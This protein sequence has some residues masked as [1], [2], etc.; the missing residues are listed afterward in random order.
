V[1]D[2][3]VVRL[4]ERLHSADMPSAHSPLSSPH[5]PPVFPGPLISY[6]LEHMKRMS[7][8][9]V[10]SASLPAALTLNMNFVM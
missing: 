5:I 1:S 10:L 3:A 8:A 7:L 4:D 2:S 9:A 6:P